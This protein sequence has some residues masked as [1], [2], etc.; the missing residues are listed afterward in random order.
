MATR[1]SVFGAR[2][3]LLKALIAFGIL[4]ALIQ[5]S[6]G[7][8]DAHATLG[9]SDPPANEV[10]SQS[11]GRVELTFTE[12]VE[13]TY[14]QIIL[15]DQNNNQVGGTAISFDASNPR[16]VRMDIPDDLA[17]GT[18]SVV[19]RT[20][21]ADDGHRFSGYFAFTI[22]S[23]SD[24]RTVIPP[25]FSTSNGVPFWVAG[26]ARWVSFLALALLS[27][28]W[29]TWLLIV[30]PALSPVWQIGPD[31]T[32]RV[33][34]YALGVGLLYV[35]AAVAMLLVQAKAQGGSDIFST[36]STILTDTRWGRFWLLRVIFGI[37]LTLAF[38]VAAWWWPRRRPLRTLGIL[39]LSAAVPPFPCPL[40]ALPFYAAFSLLLPSLP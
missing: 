8:A 38:T 40:P 27:G 18:Y 9:S 28:L 13:Q 29:L 11:P 24:V 35:L 39:A 33:R 34:S 37:A 19:W 25:T 36:M 5:G 6:V 31:V 23:T 20:L 12:A 15:V 32:R 30:R 10:V 3:G 14:T 22:G 16:I 26:V 17:K 7:R 2:P 4:V 21:S 1:T